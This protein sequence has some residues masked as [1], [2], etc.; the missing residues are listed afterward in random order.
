[1]CT[2]GVLFVGV[3][4][5]FLEETMGKNVPA[6]LIKTV[7]KPSSTRMNSFRSLQARE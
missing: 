7:A 4:E 3:K 6:R 2:S 1:M 5:T